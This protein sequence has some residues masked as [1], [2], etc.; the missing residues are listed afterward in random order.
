MN[1]STY[2]NCECNPL[3]D[4]AKSLIVSTTLHSKSLG[5]I[6][7]TR[8]T[9]KYNIGIYRKPIFN[10]IFNGEKLKEVPQNNQEQSKAYVFNI[11]P[12][13]LVRRT[14]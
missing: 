14:K 3:L 11:E 9:P 1:D 5:A 4:A 10:I 8:D 6:G 2:K 12:E 13:V 7:N